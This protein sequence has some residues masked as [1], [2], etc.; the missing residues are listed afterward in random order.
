MKSFYEFYRQVREDT[1]GQKDPIP[2]SKVN[3]QTAQAAMDSGQNDGNPRDDMVQ[4]G[5]F[6]GPAM[7]LKPSQK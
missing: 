6:D 5:K 7:K 1:I 3:A 2:L 4:V